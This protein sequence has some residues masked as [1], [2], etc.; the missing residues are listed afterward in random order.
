MGHSPE[1]KDFI[2]LIIFQNHFKRLIFFSSLLGGLTCFGFT[3]NVPTA[4]CQMPLVLEQTAN[5]R[6]ALRSLSV[7]GSTLQYIHIGFQNNDL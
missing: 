3:F 4:S 2:D 1:G 5:L 6:C 7:P